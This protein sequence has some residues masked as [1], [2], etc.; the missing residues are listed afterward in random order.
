MTRIRWFGTNWKM[1][2]SP[3]TAREWTT[4][5]G[6]YM[7]E[8]PADQRL[9]VMPPY[10]LLPQILQDTKGTGLIVGAQ[11]C[12]WVTSGAFTGEVSPQLLKE[13]GAHNV[14]LGHAERRKQFGETDEMIGRKASAALRVGL[15]VVL[16]IGED[17][18]I[19]DD[20][21]TTR[22]F[23]EKQLSIALGDIPALAPEQLVVAYEPVWAIGVGADPP[24]VY[25]VAEQLR[26]IRHVV[27]QIVNEHVP[28]VYGGS[29]TL[30]N[31]PSL[32]TETV[33]DGLFIGRHALDPAM[34][35]RIIQTA[36]GERS[37]VE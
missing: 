27:D 14:L 3:Q 25:E 11:N 6:T 36:L 8:M 35:I 10:P 9:F 7:A 34:F 24:A 18:S 26:V 30:E 12:H 13:I 15:G 22:S 21:A 16:C 5:V 1:N 28:I 37:V 29:V 20:P 17:A 23:L 33:A 31:G 19:K 4:A 32:L 2:K